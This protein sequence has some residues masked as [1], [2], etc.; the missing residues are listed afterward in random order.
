MYILA[1]AASASAIVAAIGGAAVSL[2]TTIIKA[3]QQDKATKDNT[4]HISGLNDQIK[5]LTE[6]I[7]ELKASNAALMT[8]L[9][10]M[11]SQMNPA[12]KPSSKKKKVK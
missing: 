8:E 7:I 6:Q 10:I 5:A 2:T 9:N 4:E 11:K 12:P 3:R 1:E